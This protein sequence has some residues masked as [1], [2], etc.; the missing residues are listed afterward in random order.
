[1]DYERQR[2]GTWFRRQREEHQLSI[3]EVAERLGLSVETMERLEGGHFYW[4]QIE[5]PIKTQIEE[6]L[7]PYPTYE[8]PVISENLQL[9]SDIA[10]TAY[11]HEIEEQI[12]KLKS[13]VQ[14]SGSDASEMDTKYQTGS[15]RQGYAD[16][17]CDRCPTLL[18][19]KDENCPN[20]GR[21]VDDSH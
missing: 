6:L 1:M 17:P 5:R 12:E 13:D 7:G 16:T 2:L 11:L 14:T 21:A 4:A 15:Q 20:C 9:R 10:E 3:E 8:E 18:G 19:H